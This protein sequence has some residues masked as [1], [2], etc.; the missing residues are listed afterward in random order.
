MESLFYTP[1]LNVPM[2]E[3][4]REG[5]CWATCIRDYFTRV[6]C[7]HCCFIRSTKPMRIQN[8]SCRFHESTA[9]AACNTSSMSNISL[10]I[11]RHLSKDWPLGVPKF[12][13][14]PKCYSLVAVEIAKVYNIYIYIYR[15]RRTCLPRFILVGAGT[16]ARFHFILEIFFIDDAHIWCWYGSVPFQIPQ[17]VCWQKLAF[18]GNLL[19]PKLY[20]PTDRMPQKDQK[21]SLNYD[22]P[23][24][25][26][27]TIDFFIVMIN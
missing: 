9:I 17:M 3:W 11:I 2:G 6:S 10:D 16:G 7:F 20:I 24:S 12:E 1:K 15:N 8:M 27:S 25:P 19:Y 5:L 22:S 13:K 26:V 14:K 18:P 21:E 23:Q 4:S